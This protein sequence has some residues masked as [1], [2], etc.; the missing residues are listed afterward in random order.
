MWP[1]LGAYVGAMGVTL[2]LLAA[3]GAYGLA[4][5]EVGY[6]P[7]DSDFG[8]VVVNGKQHY[9]LTSGMQQYIVFAVR[10]AKSFVK[11]ERG[12]KLRESEQPSAILEK[13][14]R[15][16]ASPVGGFAADILTGEDYRGR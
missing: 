3:P 4:H 16:K 10:M 9:D 11:R 7:E 15:G 2:G 13:F 1:D 8:K 6:D 5:I 14:A 12:E